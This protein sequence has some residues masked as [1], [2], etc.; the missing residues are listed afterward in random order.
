MAAGGKDFGRE[1]DGLSEVAG[2]FGK[3][4]DEEVAEVVAAQFAALAE[5][6]TEELGDEFFIFG[7]SDHAVAEVARGQ[8]VEVAAET[9][10]GAAIVGDGDDRGEIGNERS[11]GELGTQGGAVR[12]AELEAAQQGGKACS[13]AKSDDAQARGRDGVRGLRGH[14]IEKALTRTS[15]NPNGGR[16]RSAHFGVEQFGE[17]GIV[18]HIDKIGVAAGLDAVGR[19]ELDGAS[20]M[21]E[22]L[23][24]LAGHAVEQGHAVMGKV[25][26]RR[27]GEDGFELIAGFLIGADVEERDGVVVLL[28]GGFEAEGG[29]GA[30]ALADGEVDAGALE[31]LGR[32][33]AGELVEEDAGLLKLAL[34]H[35]LDSVLIVLEKTGVFA[36]RRIRFSGG[37][38][39]R[40]ASRGCFASF[41]HSSHKRSASKTQPEHGRL[42]CNPDNVLYAQ[43]G[44]A[45]TRGARS[46]I[47]AGI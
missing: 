34:L 36:G 13:T 44:A 32:G 31:D 38:A 26:L 2:H 4:G 1:P 24:G 25:G 27:S 21:V 29:L 3:S 41:L 23:L 18:G 10:A 42:P 43:C 6:M 39:G 47:C 16:Y 20:E 28:L 7:E 9:S 11:G 19:I 17:A 46:A 22:G 45:S 33:L 15:L 14:R 8:H 40:A 35:E 30:V 5:A 37:R 12:D